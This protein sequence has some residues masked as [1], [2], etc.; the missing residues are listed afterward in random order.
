MA[1]QSGIIP[2]SG[3]LGQLTFYKGWSGENLVRR[4]TSLDRAR[5]LNDPA[6]ERTREHM[7]EFGR[8]S[9]ASRLIRLGI[10]SQLTQLT[11]NIVSARLTTSLLKI[12]K[13]DPAGL[14]GE[15]LLERGNLE[16]L[17]NFQFNRHCDLSNLIGNNY[18]INIQNTTD[19]IKVEIKTS[20]IG[21]LLTS[22]L[23]RAVTHYRLS[24]ML[25]KL[26]FKKWENESII[27]NSSYLSLDLS[28]VNEI[29]LNVEQTYQPSIVYCIG[30]V[31]ESFQFTNGEYYPVKNSLVNAM[32]ILK[33]WLE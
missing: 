28:A 31:F 29:N 17:K 21:K 32:T 1:K 6:F 26:D 4:K 19:L 13:T 16:L 12:I 8:A 11:D 24:L 15:R 18:Q 27:A 10:Q 5:L 25:M 9:K 20:P 33:A 3:T 2:I 30:L 23:T 22:P 14:K 7:S